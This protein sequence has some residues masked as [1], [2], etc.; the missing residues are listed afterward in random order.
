MKHYKSW[1]INQKSRL[2]VSEHS[3]LPSYFYENKHITIQSVINTEILPFVFSILDNT[4]ELAK[5][6]ER[7]CEDPAVK[8]TSY[9]L[10]THKA[11]YKTYADG[12]PDYDYGL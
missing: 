4:P 9:S 12:K 11:Y 6:T 10:D 7:M 2:I 3:F 8:A 5:W 1:I